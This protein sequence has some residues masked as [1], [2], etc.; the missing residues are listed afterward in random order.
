MGQRLENP[1]YLKQAEDIF[2][3]IVGTADAAAADPPGP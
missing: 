3:Q 2:K 1:P